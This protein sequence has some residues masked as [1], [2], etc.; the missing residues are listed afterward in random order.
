MP[1]T[2]TNVTR[3]RDF[4]CGAGKLYFHVVSVQV[5]W[6]CP[7]NPDGIYEGASGMHGGSSRHVRRQPTLTAR[8]PD[9]LTGMFSF[10]LQSKP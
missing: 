6:R 9:F 3:A 1:L 4:A 2:R 10:A 5:S 7:P 8:S